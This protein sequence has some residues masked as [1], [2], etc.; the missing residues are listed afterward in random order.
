MRVRVRVRVG[1]RV[2]AGVRVR[3]RV[4]LKVRVRVGVREARLAIEAALQLYDLVLEL[5]R[6][7][8]L[9]EPG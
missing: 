5:R 3:V 2:R 9:L 8:H 1:G 6:V 7:E 4:R